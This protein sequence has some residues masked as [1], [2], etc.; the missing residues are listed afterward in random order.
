MIDPAVQ[1]DRH[2]VDTSY[3][4]KTAKDARVLKGQLPHLNLWG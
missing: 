3:L 1:R 2:A 4:A